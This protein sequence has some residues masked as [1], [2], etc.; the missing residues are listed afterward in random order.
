MTMTTTLD[1][2]NPQALFAEPEYRVEGPL[3]V[4]GAA[5]YT[6]DVS[7]PGMLWLAY[8]R[9]PRPHARIVS[10]DTSAAKQVPGVHAV[11]TG[12]DI[13][14]VGLGRRLLD[15]P[16]LATDRVRLVGDRVAA[17]AAETREAADAAARLVEVEYED[18]PLVT[19]DNALADDAQLLHP[20][21]DSYRYLGAKRPP[22]PHPNIQGYALVQ[23]SESGA[24]ID[25][26]FAQAD[27]V[28]VH[29]F[30]TAREFQGFLEP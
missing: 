21:I 23:K 14:H 19:L 13:G 12:V 9:S 20:D 1:I 22:T 18:L 2:Q 26:V 3:K 25:D 5:A 15:W 10:V 6:A 17:I 4:T 7:L 16:A 29:T 30:T 8:T 27:H 24:T 11:L 28:F